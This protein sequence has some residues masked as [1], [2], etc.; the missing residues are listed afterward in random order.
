MSWI[1]QHTWTMGQYLDLLVDKYGSIRNV[2]DKVGIDHAYLHR[3]R[4]GEKDNPSDE[5]LKKLG[6]SNPHTVYTVELMP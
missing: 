1:K 3:L 2:A 4:T 5:T 6:L